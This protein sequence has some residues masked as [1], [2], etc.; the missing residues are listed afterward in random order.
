MA[1]TPPNFNLP[2]RIWRQLGAGGNYAA[3]DVTSLVNLSVGRR[4]LQSVPITVSVNLQLLFVELLFPKLTDVRAAW[5]GAGADLVEVPA[6]SK[7]FYIVDWVEDVGK[8]FSNEYRLAI[9]YYEVAGN[10]T[11]AGGPFPA[12][13]PLP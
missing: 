3:P 10:V 4:V 13:V 12:P 2:A 9:V 6:G 7:R 5:N 11:L 1:F 8:G